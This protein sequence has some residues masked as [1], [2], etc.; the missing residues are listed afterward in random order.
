MLKRKVLSMLL[1]CALCLSTL[2][3]SASA[4][5]TASTVKH[6]GT[7][8][9]I[10]GDGYDYIAW[11]TL[12]VSNTFTASVEVNKYGTILDLPNSLTYMAYL[13]DGNGRVRSTGSAEAGTHQDN[14]PM[15]I[16]GNWTGESAYAGGA[17]WVKTTYAGTKKVV[18]NPTGIY[19]LGR[20]TSGIGSI[21]G[22]LTLSLDENGQY[23]VNVHGETYGS[24]LLYEIVGEEPDL[25]E[26][27]GTDGTE[28][29]VRTEELHPFY[30]V[31]E[32][33]DLLIP[34]YDVNGEEIGSFKLELAGSSVEEVQ[35]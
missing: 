1:A 6:K 11:C 31:E 10:S 8:T 26:A 14:F 5:S 17:V 7:N 21:L 30:D 23:P 4:V 28:G 3:V 18:V 32:G 19:Q 12:Y 15:A 22:E 27:V 2:C 33:E 13:Y 9:A 25:I 24:G 16:T 35:Q 20:S 29:Y 34:L